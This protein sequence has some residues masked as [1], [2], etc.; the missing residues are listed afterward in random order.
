MWWRILI[1]TWRFFDSPG[2]KLELWVCENGEWRRFLSPPRRRWLQL[3]YAPEWTL[4]H[5]H[6][7]LVERMAVEIADGLEPHRTR[8]FQMIDELVNGLPFKIRA[9][10][11]DLMVKR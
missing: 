3:F 8:S 11:E 4:Y 9:G 10:S 6:Q 5:A 2:A 7:N 1:P